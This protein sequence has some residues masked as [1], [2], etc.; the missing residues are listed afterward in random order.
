MAGARQEERRE[1]RERGL[2]ENRRWK[3]IYS[4]FYSFLLASSAVRIGWTGFKSRGPYTVDK[5]MN[6]LL[7]S[8]L[9]L[10]KYKWLTW[11]VTIGAGPLDL[12]HQ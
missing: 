6:S 12:V 1:E 11:R 5:R 10:F 3:M 7:C 9:E 2:P 4:C 8:D